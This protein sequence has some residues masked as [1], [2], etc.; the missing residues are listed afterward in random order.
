MI[1][2][3]NDFVFFNNKKIIIEKSYKKL[4]NK[5]FNLFKIKVFVNYFY[6]LILL[7]IINIYNVF[8]LKL[9]IF[10]VINSLFNQKNLFFTIIIFKKMSN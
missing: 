10:I 2:K 7:K 8:Y 3:E 9:L 1:F 4:N 6:K 5:M